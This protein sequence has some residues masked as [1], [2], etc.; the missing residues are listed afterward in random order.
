MDTSQ[1]FYNVLD[2]G[3]LTVMFYVKYNPETLEIQ[4]IECLL[5][6]R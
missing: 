5:G 3:I 1:N 4:T 2:M 6:K